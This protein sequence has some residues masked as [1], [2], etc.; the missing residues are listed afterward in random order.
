MLFALA[1]R[2][3]FS[4]WWSYLEFSLQVW[5][6]WIAPEML[7]VHVFVVPISLFLHPWP[8]LGIDIFFTYFSKRLKIIYHIILTEVVVIIINSNYY[9]ISINIIFVVVAIMC[10]QREKIKE[11]IGSVGGWGL[12]RR[13]F[14]KLTHKF[15]ALQIFNDNMLKI[16]VKR[17]VRTAIKIRKKYL[18]KVCCSFSYSYD[19]LI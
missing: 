13:D 12:F 15:Y 5:M 8:L 9:S 7:E 6:V 17:C 4:F 11:Q 19:L 1:K 10:L 18:Y 2:F 14:S 3:S 16:N